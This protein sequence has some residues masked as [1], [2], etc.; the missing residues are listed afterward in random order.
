VAAPVAEAAGGVPTEEEEVEVDP[1][2]Y[3]PIEKAAAAEAAEP[4]VPGI[5]MDKYYEE[6]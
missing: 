6:K 2:T 1:T 5:D 4:E 3:T